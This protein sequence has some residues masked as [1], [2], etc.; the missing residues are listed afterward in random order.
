M[1][2]L[3][4][5]AGRQWISH[6]KNFSITKGLTTIKAI[7]N[8]RCNRCGTTVTERLPNGKAYCR[9]CIGLGRVTE[10]DFLVR[11]ESEVFFKKKE[12]F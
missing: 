5:L 2:K 10:D 7:S 12:I 6:Q 11:N 4:Y 9:A 3:S 1:D 8:Q